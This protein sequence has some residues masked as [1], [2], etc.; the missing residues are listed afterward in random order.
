MSW[1]FGYLLR[2][3]RTIDAGQ[4]ADLKDLEARV[5]AIEE[6]LDKR[7]W[8]EMPNPQEMERL[9]AETQRCKDEKRKAK[10]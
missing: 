4:G 7:G 1:K 10:P 6:I 3:I 8:M 2:Y 5:T 9:A